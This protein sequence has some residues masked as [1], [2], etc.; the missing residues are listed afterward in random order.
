MENKI[1]TYLLMLLRI[2]N[3]RGFNQWFCE[4]VFDYA[5]RIKF[6]N[7]LITKP[8]RLYTLLPTV[9]YFLVFFLLFSF[10]IAAQ[11]YKKVKIYIQSPKDIPS[12]IQ[13]GVD[14]DHFH[15]PAKNIVEAFVSD[16]Q[17]EALKA[18]GFSYTI[19]IDNWYEYYKNLP[20]LS[21]GQMSQYKAS[22]RINYNVTRFGFGSMGGYYTLNEVI[23]HL[24]TMRMVFPDIISEKISIGTSIEGRPIYVVKISDNPDL[25]EDEPEVLY[26]ALHHA[27]EPQSMM[28]M[29]YFMYYLLENYNTDP[30]V[31]YLV[32]N[33]Q[34][35]FIPVVN[36]DGY[37][38]NKTI[39]PN[40]GGM[41]R[42]NRRN[43]GGG[44]F[45]VDLN[46]NYGPHQYW[47]ADNGGSSL[48]TAAETYRGTAPFSEPE[49]QAIRDFLAS[50]RIKTA[51]NY[52]TFSNLLIYPYGALNI[53]TPD[54]LIFREYAADMTRYNNYLYGTDLQTVGYATRGNSDD[55]F[56][57]G[58]TLANGG[59][60]FAMTPEV[61]SADDYFWP[62]MHR[63]FPL[64]EENVFPNLYYAWVAG[65]FAAVVNPGFQQSVFNQSDVV[66]LYPIIKNKGQS[67][68]ENI[69]VHLS[70]SSPYI[71]ISSGNFAISDLTAQTSVILTQP[72]VFQISSTAPTEQNID[73]VLSTRL[74][75][76][77]ISQDTF[78][79][80][81]GIPHY[82]FFDSSDNINDNWTLTAINTQKRW[83][84][85]TT[86]YYSP[87]SSITDSDN[88]NYDDNMSV[89][90]QLKNNINLSG[91]TYPKL[92]FW[93]KYSIEA[94]WD[95]GQVLVSSDNG[96]T[97]H[98]QKGKYT[99]TGSGG[100]QPV[101]QPVY[102]GIKN[103]W[104]REEIDL[105]QYSGKLINLK[106]SLHS[107]EYV[108][109]DGWYLDDI[110]VIVYLEI[111]VELTSFL[112]EEESKKVVLKWTTATELN[113]NGFEVQ[114]AANE[115]GEKASW[116]TIGF[117][118]GKGTSQ[119][120]ST[121]KFIDDN[122]PFSKIL[123]RLKQ[124]DFDGTFR[125]YDA[126]EVNFSGVTN[127]TLEQNY[128]N[129]FNPSTTI[130]YALPKSGFASL[131]VYNLIGEEVVVLF[132][133]FKESGRY[134]VEFS[135][136]SFGNPDKLNVHLSSGIYYYVLSIN[137]FTQVRKML[138]LR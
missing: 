92:T 77:T 41:W 132:N 36:P 72:F 65:G 88:S 100:F 28:Q 134:K 116:K 117:V 27:R 7:V 6:K 107:D 51:L 106:F 19:E 101:G 113:N 130:E 26:T 89:S 69:T 90:M 30:V 18:S 126:V 45:G 133:E 17:F 128:P 118:K 44:I 86:D 46:R 95:Y 115:S 48:S 108:N 61:G 97:W 56:Y 78:S 68:I 122:P 58:D 124:V 135:V 42:K 73:L 105:S 104:V 3:L 91:Y 39:A 87:P 25:E 33:R 64:A 20:R 83:G 9:S 13:A 131:K 35:Y 29:I 47:N 12:L 59:K 14:I 5:L 23:A 4:N 102:D 50:R 8:R 125:L 99:K 22:S 53:E 43:N 111:P 114:R 136:G 76:I 63:I 38:H 138:L 120:Q 67:N 31:K 96:V 82:I 94:N 137:G 129:P 52:H 62:P 112:A 21:D 60:I 57:D 10:N 121:Y 81:I 93:T 123:Y 16:D 40:G 109:R 119:E 70:S 1:L 75:N 79:I 84:R 32:D 49:T 24:D 2:V 55:Y 74:N 127:Y 34:M 54:S 11:N 103:Q 71:N 15:L 80:T 37:E 66:E 110:G 98:P 85:T